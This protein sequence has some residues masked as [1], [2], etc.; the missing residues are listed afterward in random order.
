MKILVL[1]NVYRLDTKKYTI[2][3]IQEEIQECLSIIDHIGIERKNAIY[4]VVISNRMTKT[5]GY[6]KRIKLKP[7]T[8]QITISANHLLW[9]N[10]Q[11]VH[12]TIM[13]EVLHSMPDC[14]NHGPKWQMYGKLVQKF[15]PKYTIERLSTDP[16]YR[17]FLQNSAKY[18]ISCKSCGWKVSYQKR[19]KSIAYLFEKKALGLPNVRYGCPICKSKELEV[20]S[21][22]S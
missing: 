22:F 18:S 13:H 8:F 5:L 15:E 2:K 21:N 16:T 10:P 7:L 4:N 20:N 17:Q 6:C 14:M 1:K 3:D 11:E 9:S 12:D 19:T